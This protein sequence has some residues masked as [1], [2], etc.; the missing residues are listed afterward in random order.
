M[1]PADPDDAKVAQVI[2]A[3][4][5]A[6]V[7][8]EPVTFER[9]TRTSKDAAREVGC[10]V[11]EIVKS[12][13]FKVA[14]SDEMVLLLLSG[15][16]RVDLE[17]A[18]AALGVAGLERADADAAKVATGYS[19]GA[20]PPFGHASPL[21][22]AL[23]DRI[24][25]FDLVWAAGGRTDTVFQISSSDLLAASGATVAHLREDASGPDV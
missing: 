13:V 24:L 20:T 25:D 15:A 21:Q 5:D 19:I 3:A 22:V 2:Q 17:R 8:I 9:E 12:L 7:T 18:A 11:A 14:M 10:D 16:D 1:R 23:D 4:A 6:G